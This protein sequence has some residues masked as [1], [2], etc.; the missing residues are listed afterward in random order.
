[1]KRIMAL[2]AA[3]SLLALFVLTSQATA[4]GDPT[5][6]VDPEYVSTAGSHTVTV[7][8]SGWAANPAITACT[9]FRGVL[10]DSVDQGST[11]ANC[12][13]LFTDM[14][15]TVSA[16]GG[17]FSTSIT[18]DVP[19]EGLVLLVFTTAPQ[20]GAPVVI[21]VG[22]PM[23]EEEEEEAAEE[24]APAEEEAAEEEAPAEEEAAEEEAPADDDM[25]DDDMG[26]RH[27]RRRHGR[28]RHGRRRHGR[29]H[30]RRRH[31]RRRHGRRRHGRRRHGDDDMADDMGD[32]DM[33]DDM[34]DD[35]APEGG[36][37]TGFGGTAGSDGNGVAVPLAATLAV[38]TLLGGAL[39][40]ARRNA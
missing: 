40:V 18:V 8:G 36:A 12:P 23:V 24:E 2:T 21:K 26:R 19:A 10:P 25:A 33:A 7:S 32:D 35:M 27:G 20:A 9:G 34:G 39:L 37:D 5:A 4:Q 30:G 3:V 16:P 38:V 15:S 13:S 1:M 11:I 29:R 31:G 6:T 22:E 28:R 14:G 17:S